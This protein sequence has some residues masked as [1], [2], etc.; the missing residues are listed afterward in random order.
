MTSALERLMASSKALRLTSHHYFGDDLAERAAGVELLRSGGVPARI[1]DVVISS[2]AQMG[3]V[4]ALAAACGGKHVVALS[5]PLIHPGLKDCARG[6]GVRLEP[7]AID[8]E[9]LDPSALD[10]AC[11]HHRPGAIILSANCQNPTLATMSEA[12]RAAIAEVARARRVPIIEDDVYGWLGA[13]RAPSFPSFCP[14][15]CWYITSLSKNVAVGLRIGYM[16]A[17]IGEG[18]RAARIQQ[19]YSQHVSWLLSAL[20]A[21]LIGSGDARRIMDAVGRETRERGAL[22]EDALK[23]FTPRLALSPANSFAWLDL[24][25][26]WRAAEFCDALR[27]SGVSVKPAEA[28]AVG[29]TSA[30]HAVRIAYGEINTRAELQTGLSRIV[31]TLR[32]GPGLPMQRQVG[33]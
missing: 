13:T 26:P 27:R 30:P 17:P 1:E 28:F 23:P 9:G 7:V 32:D 14:E 24:P 31:A 12:R 25:E 16:L 3:L 29:R 21:E 22:V 5:E 19:S 8:G 33:G 11:R 2:G 18:A 4:T 6:I 15:L 20:A 10:D